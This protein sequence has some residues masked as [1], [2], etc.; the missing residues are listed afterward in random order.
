MLEVLLYGNSEDGVRYACTEMLSHLGLPFRVANN[1]K[2]LESQNKA[3]QVLILPETSEMEPSDG[4]ILGRSQNALLLTGH[5]P[6][7]L[8]EDIRCRIMNH[9]GKAPPKISGTL[10][11]K[12]IDTVPFFY[13]F[14]ALQFEEGLV[15]QLGKIESDDGSSAGVVLGELNGRPIAIIAPP[16]FKSASYLLA[17]SEAILSDDTLSSLKLLDKHGRIDGRRIEISRKGFLRT[18]IVNIY[19]RLLFRVLL[20]FA[21]Q[22]NTPLVHKWFHPRNHDMCVSLAHDV[23]CIG[24]LK[25]FL[26]AIAALRSGRIADCLKISLL[27]LAAAMAFIV[28]R[29]HISASRD[30]LKFLPKFMS[31]RLLDSSPFWN[32]GLLLSI[33]QRFGATSSFYFL[34]NFADKDS[35]YDFHNPLIIEVLRFLREKGCEVGLHGSYHSHDNIQMIKRE[36]LSLERALGEKVVGTT[37]HYVRIKV[38]NTWSHQEAL[39]FI[40]DSS[41]GYPQDSGFRAATCLPFKPWDFKKKRSLSI[42]EIPFSLMDGTLYQE[43]Y[44]AVGPEKGFEISKQLVD[45]IHKYQGVLALQWHVSTDR[46]RKR[47]WFEL[48]EKILAYSSSFNPW[49]TN[50]QK[51]A[52][53]WNFRSKILFQESS[54]NCSE[55]KFVVNSPQD[56][57]NLSLRAYFPS[58]FQRASVRVNDQKITGKNVL[59]KGKFLLFCFNLWKGRNELKISF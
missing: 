38:P 59:E 39:G 8:C 7:E 12:G 22:T 16:I 18:P 6:D 11:V 49:Y 41:F 47:S 20:E 26:S 51:L 19:E 28:H 3:S 56:Y 9:R 34:S 45:T 14:P 32:F 40:Y 42:L 36:K 10:M 24:G 30:T 31:R 37:Q 35:D 25:T 44:L 5:V 17:G 29:S 27:T 57:E 4:I 43:E 23:E 50:G 52:E 1:L 58:G 48:Y 54:Y 33:E 55:L 2:I 46:E 53:W 15:R 21:K 13:Q